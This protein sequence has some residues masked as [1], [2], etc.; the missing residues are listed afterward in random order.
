MCYTSS[1]TYVQL[2]FYLA[3]FGVYNMSFN[4]N[5][6]FNSF[7]NLS[8]KQVLNALSFHSNTEHFALLNLILAIIQIEKRELVFKL[9]FKS[10]FDYLVNKLKFSEGAANRRIYASR[11]IALFPSVFSLLKD[12]HINLTTVCTIRKILN[13]D[14]VKDILNSVKGKSLKE[15][16]VIVSKYMPHQKIADKVTPFNVKNVDKSCGI[17]NEKNR[18]TELKNKK[19]TAT[20]GGAKAKNSKENSMIAK[21]SAGFLSSENNINSEISDLSG[22]SK[23]SEKSDLPKHSDKTINVNTSNKTVETKF[24]LQFGVSK[25]FMKKF[26]EVKILLSGKYPNG[27]SMEQLFEECMDMLIEKKSPVK[28]AERRE[29]RLARKSEK[30]AKKPNLLHTPKANVG[31]VFTPARSQETGKTL[32][33]TRKIPISIR[34]EVYK[35]ANGMCT[36]TSED[37]K[38]C[39]S[40]WDLEIEHENPVS[41]GG[42]NNIGNLTLHCRKHNLLKAKDKMGDD[43]I[44]RFTG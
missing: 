27:I 10:T 1:Y 11:C 3:F 14:N 12:K 16:Q 39:K 13:K 29:L 37:G 36:Y 6:S 40:R 15:V 33:K 30:T 18:K 24:K 42:N 41:F 43:F 19:V 7:N 22:L 34:D 35:R 8:D 23:L 44:K 5:F 25:E 21:S 9:G 2:F 28:R 38:Q 17:D 26:D 4:N 31:A 20:S 32:K